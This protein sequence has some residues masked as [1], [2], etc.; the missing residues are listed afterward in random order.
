MVFNE[1]ERIFM[2][3]QYL[4]TKLFTH[5]IELCVTNFPNS[6]PPNKSSINRVVSKF[7]STGSVGNQP[8]VCR[9]T[10]LLRRT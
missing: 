8:E 2:V 3:E 1:E 9:H 5:G 10:M 6:V 4:A 7:R